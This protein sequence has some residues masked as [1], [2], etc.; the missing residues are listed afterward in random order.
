[1]NE[2]QARR[3]VPRLQGGAKCDTQ[4]PQSSGE[5]WDGGLGPKACCAGIEIPAEMEF[6]GAKRQAGQLG[7]FQWLT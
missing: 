5:P 7:N 2:P 1:M 3:G 4:L 6:S